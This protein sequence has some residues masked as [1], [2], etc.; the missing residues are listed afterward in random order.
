MGKICFLLLSPMQEVMTKEA[1]VL[2]LLSKPD[3]LEPG[4]RDYVGKFNETARAIVTL[5]GKGDQVPGSMHERLENMQ[6]MIGY[7]KSAEKICA[8]NNMIIRQLGVVPAS[9]EGSAE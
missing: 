6:M 5:Q 4:L 9:D 8:T 1:S 2:D 7:Y 3:G